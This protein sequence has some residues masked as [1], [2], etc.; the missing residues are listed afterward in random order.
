[1]RSSSAAS[2]SS[3]APWGS[4]LNLA[5]ACLRRRG[6]SATRMVHVACA[7]L[8]NA[9]QMRRQMGSA[10]G[11]HS[12][13]RLPPLQVH[14]MQMVG[15]IVLGKSGG[16]QQTQK[17]SRRARVGRNL[18]TLTGTIQLL[19]QCSGNTQNMALPMNRSRL[20]NGLSALSVAATKSFQ[21]RVTCCGTNES[22]RARRRHSSATCAPSPLDCRTT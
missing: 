2:A 18:A 19:E 14:R 12:L 6:V 22:T 16:V 20:Q 17:C 10:T 5:A 3:T 21:R 4:V 13:K 7:L 15:T 1:M 8:Q 9:G 11:M